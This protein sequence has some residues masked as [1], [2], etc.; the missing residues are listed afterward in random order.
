[1]SEAPQ[2]QGARA[3]QI[4]YWRARNGMLSRFGDTTGAGLWHIRAGHPGGAYSDLGH[5]L[6]PPAEH[7]PTLLTRQD[8]SGSQDSYRGACLR[9]TWEGSQH[10]GPGAANSAVEEAHDHAFPG[11]RT[12]PNL[13]APADGPA[14]RRSWQA[15][16]ACYPAEW[17]D[18]GAPVLRPAVG[19]GDQ[20]RPPHAG[21]PRYELRILRPAGPKTNTSEGQEPLF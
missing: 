13:P 3:R 15:A 11:W 14:A 17:L 7:T 12:L 9:C 21:R 16:A 18:R 10:S 6:T 20:H 2:P 1:V 19:R 4:Q 8:H 5:E